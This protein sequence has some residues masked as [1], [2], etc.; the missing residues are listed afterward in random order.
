M[1]TSHRTLHMLPPARRVA[2]R[3]LARAP[4][5]I[6]LVVA[7]ACATAGGPP[8]V[9]A[10]ATSRGM[11]HVLTDEELGRYP[12]PAASLHDRVRTL[13]TGYVQRRDGEE[14]A[15]FIDGR[16]AGPLTVLDQIP[17][18]AVREIR[19][20][21]GIEVPLLFGQRQRHAVVLDVILRH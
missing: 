3:V 9:V 2:R 11:L 14:P 6:A 20:L 1:R 21:R 19:L 13:R 15:V 18:Y 7:A 5:A 4:L 12:D 17:V 8:V 10:T 16:Y